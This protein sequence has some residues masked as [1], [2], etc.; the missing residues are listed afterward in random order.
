MKTKTELM[1]ATMNPWR[2]FFVVAIPG[3]VSMFAM[4]VYSVLEGI[5]IGHALGEEAF[6][7]INIA[8]PLV[9]ITNSLADLIGVGASV[10]ISIALGK[11]DYKSANNTFTV[12]VIM[13]F[14]SSVFMGSIMFFAAEPLASM[15][16]ADGTL[17]STSARYL[18]TSAV[19]CPLASIFFAMDNYLRISGY[20]RMSMII[21]VISNVLTIGLMSVFLFV[22]KMDVSGSALALSISMSAC[23]LV[24]M[25]PFVARRALLKFKKPQFSR[26]LLK[27]IA[28]CGSPVFLN[29]IAGRITSIIMNISLMMVGAKALGEGGGTTAVAVYAVLMYS[30][31]MCWPLLYGIA[32]SLAPSLGYNWGAKNYSRVKRIARCAYVGTMAVGLVSTSVLFFM[33][34]VIASLFV[35]AQDVRLLE[36]AADAIRIFCLTYLF[37]WI[38]VTTQ[39]YLSAIE[40]PAR[41]TVMALSIAF[42]FPVVL[43]GALWGFGLSGIW[44]N[45]VGVNILAAILSAVFLV[46]LSREIKRRESE[47]KTVTQKNA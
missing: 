23:S 6:A 30:S 33:P 35:D 26:P 13:I 44:F 38:A 9:L 11:E 42:V 3:M 20:V 14:A 45:F 29:N 12:S 21:N 8:F 40:K 28:A 19:F 15:M 37:R 41:A 25:I 36:M 16:G 43:L 39:S 24:A 17:L 1:Y 5:F 2:L 22:L 47:Y 7:A 10:P 27:Q 46:S 31:D 32:D 4:S 18:R 34:R